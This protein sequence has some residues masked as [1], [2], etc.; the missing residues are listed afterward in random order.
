MTHFEVGYLVGSFA[1]T[2][3]RMNGIG[4]RNQNLAVIIHLWNNTSTA[5]LAGH[6]ALM[7]KY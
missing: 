3:A 7:K 5:A 4:P 1:S 6:T 2:V